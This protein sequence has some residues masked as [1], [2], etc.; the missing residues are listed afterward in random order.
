MKSNFV[1]RFLLYLIG[2][3]ASTAQSKQELNVLYLS[4]ENKYP[5]GI[6]A[7]WDSAA[8][9]YKWYSPA[10]G[11]NKMIIFLLL[12]LLSYSVYAQ[13]SIFVRIYDLRGRKIYRGDV[14]TVSDSSLSLI[15]KTAPVNIPVSMIGSIKTRH[16]A[17]NNVLIGSIIGATTGSIIGAASADPH[18]EGFSIGPQT[19]GE[20]ALG[21]IL[22]GA[23]LGAAVGGLTAVFKNVDIFSINGD[24]LRWKEFHD[25]ALR[26]QGN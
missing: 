15:G 2:P 11:L 5:G 26:K 24:R 17:G 25:F 9:Q 8:K 18:S 21:G 16:S 12:V 10:N 13:K 20:G 22:I 19:A 1:F 23:P 7:A 4:Q 14:Y 3:F 6:Y